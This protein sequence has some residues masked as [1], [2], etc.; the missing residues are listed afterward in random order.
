MY[1]CKEDNKLVESLKKIDENSHGILFVIDEKEH[2]IG[3]VT[4]GDIR[5]WLLKT[6]DLSAEVRCFMNEKPLALQKNAADTSESFMKKNDITAV[7]IIDSHNRI[8][9]IHFLIRNEAEKSL[10]KNL[11]NVTVCIMAGGKGTRLKPYTNILPKPLIPI[12]DIPIAERIIE[13]FEKFGAKKFYMTVNYKKKMIQSYFADS[14]REKCIEYLEESEPLGT[15][16]SLSMLPDGG[17]E[18]IFVSNCDILIKA[19]YNDIYDFH[20]KM[21][22]D[23]TV[24]TALKN[25]VVPYGVILS[26]EN[27][28]IEAVDE[29]PQLSYLV[30]TGFYVLSPKAVSMVPKNREYHMT[31]LMTDLIAEGRKVAMYPVSEDSFLDMGEFEEMARMEQKLNK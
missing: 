20:L 31:D 12:G 15:A 6:G 18:P 9:D 14:D 30:N 2:L 3:T 19:N 26:S 10:I 13:N 16:G 23:M 22:N 11:E 7:P 21:E 28:L 25:I 17:K 1:L 24:V 5:R 8:K 4:D 27:G 29:K